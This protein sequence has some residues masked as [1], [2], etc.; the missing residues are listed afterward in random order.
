MLAYKP[1]KTGNKNAVE[2]FNG[3]DDVRHGGCPFLAV[4]AKNGGQFGQKRGPAC[5]DRAIS[6]ECVTSRLIR[7]EGVLF[8]HLRCLH[9]CG[10]LK[11][12][13]WV[14][15][16]HKHLGQNFVK[17]HVLSAHKST[18][19]DD[20][21]AHDIHPEALAAQEAGAFNGKVKR[22]GHTSN[23]CRGSKVNVRAALNRHLG[24]ASNVHNVKVMV[25]LAN[26][27]NAGGLRTCAPLG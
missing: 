25:K 10:G 4:T 2:R 6:W 12:S 18:L 13:Q 14:Y 19:D 9:R 17:R 27:N 22:R 16:W 7:L 11:V 24:I 5:G 20:G 21:A 3:P 15:G 26:V 1:V 23:G 8:R